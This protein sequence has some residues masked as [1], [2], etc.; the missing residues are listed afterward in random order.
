MHC[1]VLLQ[2]SQA[3]TPRARLSSA[4]LAL[5]YTLGTLTRELVAHVFLPLLQFWRCAPEEDVQAQDQDGD[6]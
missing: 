4:T 1:H 6:A 5:G 3:Q 2:R